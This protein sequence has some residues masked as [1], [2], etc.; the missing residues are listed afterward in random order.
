[1]EQLYESM[2][3]GGGVGEREFQNIIGKVEVQSRGHEL[4][5]FVEL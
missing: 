1:M 3:Y 4:K 2:E 5:D